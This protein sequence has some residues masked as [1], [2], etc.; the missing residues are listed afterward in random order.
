MKKTMCSISALLL[1]ISACG[2]ST[3][4]EEGN[5]SDE[6]NV[7]V[8]EEEDEWINLFN[9]ENLEGWT[10]YGESTVGE[11]WKVEDGVIHFDAAAKK[12]NGVAGGDLVTKESF[13]D[14]HLK[15]EWKISKNG[16]SGIMFYVV[17]NGEFDAPYHTGP[18]YQLLDN[19]GHPDGKITTHRTADLYDLIESS[20]EPV[21]PVGEWNLTEIISENGK[22]E[23]YLNGVQTVST[24]MWDKEWEEMVAN[25]KFKDMPAF[26][27]HQEGKIALQDHGD[28]IWFRNIMIKKL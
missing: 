8:M 13:E 21:K 24:T 12:N 10:S 3:T 5:M 18:E 27:K 9:G 7:A 19:E 16:N 23:F 26:G 28:E 20:E 11:A 22:L 4:N 2:T 14:F 1:L 15:L 17:D 6:Q 25:S